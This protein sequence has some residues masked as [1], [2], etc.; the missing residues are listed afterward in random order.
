MSSMVQALP[1]RKQRIAALERL[2]AVERQLFV[3]Q[4]YEVP[5]RMIILEAEREL[6]RLKGH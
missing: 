4:R 1:D 3:D 2:I 6:R 5:A